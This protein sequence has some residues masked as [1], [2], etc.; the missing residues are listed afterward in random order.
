MA[1]RTYLY[2][3]V[4]LYAHEVVDFSSQYGSETSISYTVSNIAG[5]SSTY[6]SYGDF[7]QTAVLVGKLSLIFTVTG[8]LFFNFLPAT[9]ESLHSR[10][11]WTVPT[12]PTPLLRHCMQI[13]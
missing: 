10:A 13:I 2:D 9:L 3:D 4:R 5:R 1:D 7:T 11:P 6:P 12:L 8:A